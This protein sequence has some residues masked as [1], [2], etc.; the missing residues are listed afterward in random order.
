[1]T[2]RARRYIRKKKVKS[3]RMRFDD[4]PEHNIVIPDIRKWKGGT[5]HMVK[6]YGGP[7]MYVCQD[8]PAQTED[9]GYV[10]TV[11]LVSDDKK[12]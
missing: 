6:L 11:K 4:N 8:E 3:V 10:Y 1:M 7:L 12:N 9:G 2:K 5:S